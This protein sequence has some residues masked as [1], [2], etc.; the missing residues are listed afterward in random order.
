[1]SK[2]IVA[3]SAFGMGVDYPHVRAVIHMGPPRDMISFTQEVGRLGRDGRGGI[4]RIVL[5]HNWQTSTVVSSADRDMLT[6]PELAMRL[7]LGQCRCL[8]AV[9]SRFQDGRQYMK[10]CTG[11]DRDRWCSP[12]Q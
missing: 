12:C 5:A 3:T 9:L 11:S 2:V 1:M 6:L 8:V 10:Y 7:Y 4:S